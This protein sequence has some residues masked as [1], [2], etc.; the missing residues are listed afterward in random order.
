MTKELVAKTILPRNSNRGRGRNNNRRGKKTSNA[1]RSRQ[2]KLPTGSLANPILTVRRMPLFGLR[3]RKRLQYFE[4]VS[5]NGTASAVYSYVFSANGVFDPDITGTGH[6]PMGFDQMMVFYNHYTVMN[7]KIRCVYQ[8]T[9]TV[10]THVA[11]SIS[12]TS[13]TITDY[14]QLVENGELIYTVITPSGI[15]GSIATLRHS[16]NC[17]VFQGL[18]D[19]MDDPDMRG[20]VASNPAEL[21]YY[22][23]SFWNPVNATVPSVLLD[24]YIEYDVMFHE[25]RK[26]SLS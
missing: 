18:Q 25:P 1:G 16:V 26:G 21:V 5:T 19:V 22:H 24:V 3:T 8:N 23:L 4:A 12:G 17:A 14:L 9:G 20:D 15:A 11:L 13:T 10:D 2:P 6:Q 7:S